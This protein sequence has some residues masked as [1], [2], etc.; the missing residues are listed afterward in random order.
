MA[1]VTCLES[2][3]NRC[4]NIWTCTFSPSKQTWR[5]DYLR[6]HHVI[7]KK[8]GFTKS[9]IPA[10]WFHELNQRRESFAVFDVSGARG[11]IS[12][13]A[14]LKKSLILR[15]QVNHNHRHTW[16]SAYW[17]EGESTKRQP[18]NLSTD[19]LNTCSMR[20]LHTAGAHG[21]QGW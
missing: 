17:T 6:W 15:S 14:E 1:P 19:A 12:C 8:S 7:R 21:N 5:K 13:S 16:H 20:S 10:A 18:S 9:E 11:V 3:V 4:P 2:I